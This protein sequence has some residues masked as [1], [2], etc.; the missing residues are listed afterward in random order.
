MTL[1]YVALHHSSPYTAPTPTVFLY[2][3]AWITC[4][5]PTDR[6]HIKRNTI[7]PTVSRR[8]T[9]LFRF[10]KIHTLKEI[11]DNRFQILQVLN[12]IRFRSRI[13]FGQYIALLN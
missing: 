6:P 9:V 5:P 8:L 2:R 13:Q 1:A 4:F 3:L 11:G 7:N 12:S 10:F